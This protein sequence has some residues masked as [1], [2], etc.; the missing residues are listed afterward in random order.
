MS[1]SLL[2][3]FHLIQFFSGGAIGHGLA[4]VADIRSSKSKSQL[5]LILRKGLETFGSL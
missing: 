1:V 2:L 5:E 3:V 4:N